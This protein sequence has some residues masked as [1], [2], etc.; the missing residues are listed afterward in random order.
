MSDYPL[1][2][3]PIEPSR[4]L[5]RAMTMLRL[6]RQG[7]RD[8]EETE[9]DR[10]LLGFFAVVI[11][12]RAVTNA[13]QNLRTF[14]RTAFDDWYGPWQLQMKEDPLLLWFYR[15]RTELLKDFD[16]AIGVV[17]SAAGSKAPAPGTV[18]VHGWPP[19]TMHKLEQIHDTTTINLC[20]M[21]LAYLEEMVAAAAGV[22]W[23]VQDRHDA[24]HAANGGDEDSRES[25]DVSDKQS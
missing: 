3:I 18:T 6:V 14:D 23:Q 17:V 1:L 5:T 24:A 12:G 9:Y 2:S 22:I 7:L 11:F 8:M 15:L 13:L 21:Y 10:V 20:R 19:P 4:V 25:A 16:P